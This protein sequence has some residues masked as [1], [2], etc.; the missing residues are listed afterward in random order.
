[1]RERVDA[2]VVAREGREMGRETGGAV[3]LIKK[4][5]FLVGSWKKIHSLSLYLLLSSPF[6]LF[7]GERRICIRNDLVLFSLSPSPAKNSVTL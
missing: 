5:R 3:W 2:V 1:M 4:V 6:L 7:Y